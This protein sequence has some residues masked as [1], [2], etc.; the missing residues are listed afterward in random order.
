MVGMHSSICWNALLW[1]DLWLCSWVRVTPFFG[2]WSA[3]WQ[4]VRF[5]RTFPQIWFLISRAVI[6][7]TYC[8]RYL[9]HI[10]TGGMSMTET[11]LSL[12]QSNSPLP[13]VLIIRNEPSGSM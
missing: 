8:M 6:C 1:N 12:L 13:G 3:R 4:D 9:H 2:I 7:F 11:N 10:V 5:I